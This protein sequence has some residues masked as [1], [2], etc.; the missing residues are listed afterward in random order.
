MVGR[1]GLLLLVIAV[2][3]GCSG[4]PKPDPG[5][6]PKVQHPQVAAPV[7]RAAAAVAAGL[8]GLDACALLRGGT[9]ERT[10]PHECVRSFG[11]DLSVSVTLG[12]HWPRS[13]RFDVPLL[14]LAGAKVYLDRSPYVDESASLC[15][16][17]IPVSFTD[18]IDVTVGAG[19][20]AA[21][22]VCPQARAYATA[23]IRALG[24]GSARSRIPAARWYSCT[25]LAKTLRQ[26]GAPLRHDP[27]D[28][29]TGP[30]GT[31]IELS[32]APPLDPN[33]MDTFR[34]IGGKPVKVDESKACRL[35]WSQTRAGLRESPRA[36]LQVTVAAPD[37]GRGEKL[38]AAAMTVLAGDVPAPARSQRPLTYRPNQPDVAAA[39]AC[40]RLRDDDRC[41]PYRRVAAP[42]GAVEVRRRAEADPNVE[43]A[44]AVDA[45]SKHLGAGL[46]PVTTGDLCVFA[47]TTHALEVAV[48]VVAPTGEPPGGENAK[49]LTVAGRS[50]VLVSQQIRG[51][52][53]QPPVYRTDDLYVDASVGVR[54]HVRFLLAPARGAARTDT[55]RAARLEPLAADI[56][57]SYL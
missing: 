55:G 51:S 7:D 17:R 56:L 52:G 24:S 40:A 30:G 25:L 14:V 42:K 9:A 28:R 26:P 44:I 12:A 53:P 10:A 37:C 43:C 27:L 5:P 15:Q 54:L 34:T 8:T 35:T 11:G 57:T 18:V 29:C 47:E 39:G 21:A 41:Q 2:V 32:Y 23:A 13:R 22:T 45:V 46:Q 50:A 38:V 6:L 48:E 49:Q 31:G 36:A 3:A 33:A 1:V 20:S 4:D 19:P 16:A